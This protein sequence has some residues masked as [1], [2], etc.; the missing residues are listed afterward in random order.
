[1]QGTAKD[2]DRQKAPWNAWQ[3]WWTVGIEGIIALAVG[4]FMLA[5]PSGASDVIRFLIA[6]VLLL[7]SLGH[8]VDGFRNRGL[9]SSPWET[10]RGGIG[11]TVAVLTLLSAGSNHVADDV[12]RQL[13]A[14]GLLVY[15]LLGLVS[16][17][18]T[19]RSTRF[20][21]AAII[22][23]ILTIALGVL[24]LRARSGD[25][26]GTQLLGAVAAVGGIAL[27]GYSWYLRGKPAR[28][29]RS[30]A[31]AGASQATVADRDAV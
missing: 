30:R 14:I 10:L 29:A 15:G 28:E 19:F 31:A 26:R 23:D 24:L 1:M 6:L 9:S 22:A 3:T 12:A 11:A 18:F 13:L 17:I 4:V 21:G 25:T 20:N 8:I 5:N 16:L 27:L 7:D 2:V